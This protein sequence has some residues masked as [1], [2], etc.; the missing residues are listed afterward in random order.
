M[1]VIDTHSHTWWWWRRRKSSDKRALIFFWFLFFHFFLAA[2]G[3]APASW[4]FF[5]CR[6][7]R[8]TS[9]KTAVLIWFD[10][11]FR[12]LQRVSLSFST[13]SSMGLDWT[14]LYLVLLGFDG[15]SDWWLSTWTSS[16]EFHCVSL[17][18]RQDFDVTQF[19]RV[20]PSFTE[21]YRVSPSLPRF[22]ELI[23]KGRRFYPVLPSFTGF[24]RHFG[25]IT[26][27]F[28]DFHRVS[29]DSSH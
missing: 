25:F 21:F 18:H 19:Y 11:I 5:F 16:T 8:G 20:L 3:R 13:S 4:M 6:R 23:I 15:L 27:E 24:W 1:N 7:R 14:E 12:V 28:H 29:P 17:I 22:L 9:A 2:S 26:S 10:S